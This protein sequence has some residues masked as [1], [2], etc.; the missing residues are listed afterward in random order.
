MS[1]KDSL[2]DRMKRYEACAHYQLPM[3]VPKL[4]RIDGKAFHTYLGGLKG[5]YHKEVIDAMIKGAIEVMTEIG[6]MARFAYI[7]SDECTIALNDALTL[8]MEPWF[9][10][11]IQKMVSVSASLFANGF[12]YQYQHSRDLL[13]AFDARVFIVPNEMEVVN[14][15]IWRQQ[16]AARNSVNTYA[17]TLYSHAELQNKNNSQMQDMMHEKGL[18]WNDCPTWTKR[19]VVVSREGVDWEI[20][21]F[22]KDH[23]YLLN[24]F[25]PAKPVEPAK[26]PQLPYDTIP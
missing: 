1:K 15:L 20:P 4:I 12:N 6:G 2:G 25:T 3:R 16:D 23:Y 11:Q 24:K 17:R 22:S 8:D 14:N 21:E 26:E 7:Q 9:N 18:N 10:N 19:G 13:A 5:G